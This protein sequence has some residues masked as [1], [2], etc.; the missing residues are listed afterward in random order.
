MKAQ[1]VIALKLAGDAVQEIAVGVEPRDLVLVL[2]RHQLE[3]RAR[4]GFGQCRAA[5]YL[6]RLGFEQSLHPVE[7][8][9]RIGSVLILGQKFDAPSDYL[10]ECL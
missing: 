1:F 3:Q 8:P 2:V 6:R 10:V 5:G 9:A 7:I 4:R